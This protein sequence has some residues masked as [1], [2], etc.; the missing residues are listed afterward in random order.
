M[1]DCRALRTRFLTLTA[2]YQG[3][4]QART[5]EALAAILLDNCRYHKLNLMAFWRHGTVEF[6]QHSGTIDAEK[7]CA[8]ISL[9]QGFIEKALVSK[10]FSAQG[11]D[12]ASVLRITKVSAHTRRFYTTRQAHFAAAA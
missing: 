5:L 4:E 9:T 2:A 7:I 10:R 12:L 11:S 6:R 1:A 3:I 8:W